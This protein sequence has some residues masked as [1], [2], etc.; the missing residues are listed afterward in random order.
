MDVTY[1]VPCPP[2]NLQLSHWDKRIGPLY[3]MKILCFPLSYDSDLHKEHI[4]QLLFEALQST[5]EKLPFLAGSV[6]PFSKDTPWLYHLRPEGAAYLEVKD[7]SSRLNFQD[8]RKASFSPTLLDNELLCPYPKAVCIREGPADCC[9]LRANFVKGGLL[10]V[11]SII[12]TVCDGRGITEVLKVFAEMFRKSQTG[13][14][15]SRSIDRK[16]TPKHIYSYDRTSVLSGNGH[17][18]TIQHH[19]AWDASPNKPRD[20][21]DNKKTRCTIF[22]IR[23]EYLEILKTTATPSPQAGLQTHRILIHDGIAALIWRCIMLARRRAGLISD[24][25]STQFCTA[26]DCRSRLNL[27]TPYFGNANYA[28]KTSLPKPQLAPPS[29][30]DGFDIGPA[31]EL[32]YAAYNIRDEVNGVTADTFRDLLAFVERT[33]EKSVTRLS[34]WDDVLVG[35]LLLISYFWF[36][37]HELDFGDALGGKIEAFRLPS[38]GLLPGMPVVLPR[39]PDGS[40]E[41]MV[42]EEEEVLIFLRKDE[43]FRAFAS[44][45]C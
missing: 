12:H 39:L 20:I 34:V 40:C 21:S 2:F 31:L 37:M 45:R 26:V 4:A 17:L 22:H 30:H 32:Q 3:S 16:E 29:I 38:G 15:I 5:V 28:I 25:F 24:R 18:G 14:L 10:L 43:Q 9:R 36:K 6:V 13:E 33:E 44:E 23:S 7:F 42:N 19:P 35:S 11:I 1:A 8:L 27:P 41:F